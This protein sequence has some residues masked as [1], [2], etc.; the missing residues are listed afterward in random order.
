MNNE[1]VYFSS[2]EY[3]DTIFSIDSHFNDVKK[4]MKD[5]KEFIDNNPTDLELMGEIFPNVNYA[6]NT[7]IDDEEK[8]DFKDR[9]GVN[10]TFKRKFCFYLTE[11]NKSVYSFKFAI[12]Q[13]KFMIMHDTGHNERYQAVYNAYLEVFGIYRS[14][15]YNENLTILNYLAKMEG[16]S[17]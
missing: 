17:K 7:A 12:N 11:L 10:T 8:C 5:L 3:E 14:K 6:I 13:L 2:S 1:K 9:I 16:E 15:I 4:A